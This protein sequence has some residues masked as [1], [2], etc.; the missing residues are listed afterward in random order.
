MS[1]NLVAKNSKQKGS[2]LIGSAAVIG[3]PNAG[4]SSLLN[5]I[6]GAKLSIVSRKAQTTRHKIL[7]VYSDDKCQVRFLDTPGFQLEHKS[8]LNSAMNRSVSSSLAEV[9]VIIFVLEAGL[10][11]KNDLKLIEMF[12]GDIP[13]VCAVSKIDQL[14]SPNVVLPFIDKVKNLYAFVDIIPT[15]AQ[16]KQ[17]L[18]SLIAS[19]QSKCSLGE[20]VHDEDAL[21]DR[22]ERFFASEIIR[23][24]L[25]HLMGD[26]I[27]YGVTV[28]IEEFKIEKG[29]R[30]INAT[31][32]VAKSAHKGMIIGAQGSKLKS[33]GT[34]ARVEMEYFF[35]GKV[36]LK[37][38]VK[39]KKG[40]VDDSQSVK[41]FGYE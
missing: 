16:R 13:V 24:K 39:V 41:Y 5:A 10:I 14:A 2:I 21:T 23:E 12:P 8:M 7:G 25:F 1:E 38:W 17:G 22:P 30:S 32:V 37:L 35:D 28:E 11:Q 9:D 3:V 36:F 34:K 40:W 29:L 20:P 18:D 4:K 6:L 15:S 26:E 27:P 33:I 31:I 19:I